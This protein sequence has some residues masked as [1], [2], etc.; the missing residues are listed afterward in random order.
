MLFS[1]WVWLSWISTV[2]YLN[3]V[4]SV[5]VVVHVA[6]AFVSCLDLERISEKQAETIGRKDNAEDLCRSVEMLLCQY[7]CIVFDC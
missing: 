2:E 4:V 1:C 6:E 3:S 7:V 5:Q